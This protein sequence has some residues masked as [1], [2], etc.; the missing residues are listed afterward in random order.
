LLQRTA[1]RRNPCRIPSLLPL[2]E[3]LSEELIHEVPVWR[4]KSLSPESA[5]PR[6]VSVV[7]F[8]RSGNQKSQFFYICSYGSYASREVSSFPSCLLTQCST[9]FQN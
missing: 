4:G 3:P 8:T 7:A 5:I 6:C 9:E 1:S 2:Y